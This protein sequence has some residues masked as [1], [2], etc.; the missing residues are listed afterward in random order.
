[1]STTEISAAYYKGSKQFEIA[2]IMAPPPLAGEVQIRTAYVGI[3]GTDLHAFHGRMDTRIG[4]NRIIGHEMSGIV[5]NVGE[6]VRHLKPGQHVVVR[7]LAHC[8]ECP[9]CKSG[10]QHICHNLKFLG[11]DTDG[12][13]QQLWTV[14][15]HTV[16]QIPESLPL[17]CAAL[18]EPV[19]VA[20][21]GVSRSRL[22]AGENV[23]V[24][25]GGPIGLL[26]AMV[27]KHA[28]GNIIISEVSEARLAIA[29]K[30]GFKVLNPSQQD[31]VASV[32][33]ETNARGAD[34]IFEVSGTQPGVD[35]MTKIAASRA[36]IVMTA[37]HSEK[38]PID[39]FQFFWREIELIGARVYTHEDYEKAIEL[40]TNGAIDTGT[41]I[42]DVGSLEN[43]Q[44]AFEA[45]EGN[46]T[47]MKSLIKVA[48]W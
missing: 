15:E 7:P 18:I 45:L 31:I 17:E 29:K 22:Q 24:I 8:S 32:M 37:I 30:L 10:L 28:G 35:T 23:V 39:L 6:G 3:C 11:L 25:G 5:E 27:A 4:C 12:A 40:V 43:I 26:I 2:K 47:A 14:P 19:S 46:P 36:R 48:D 13:F 42:T 20:C 34:V 9:A 41:I 16:H 38:R 44:Q 21:H 1:M 33:T